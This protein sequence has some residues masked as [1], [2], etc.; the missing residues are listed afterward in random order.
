MTDAEGAGPTSERLG[1][2][3]SAVDSDRRSRHEPCLRTGEEHRRRSE[4][5]RVTPAAHGRPGHELAAGRIRL[6]HPGHL[7]AEEARQDRI[8][9][10]AVGRPLDS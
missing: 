8:D 9:P 6:E 4:L 7:G 2:A 10:D 3:P 1:D 5:L